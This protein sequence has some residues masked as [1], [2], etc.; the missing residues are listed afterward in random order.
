MLS[1]REPADS[2][3]PEWLS[4]L[5][6]ELVDAGNDAARVDELLAATFERFRSARVREFVPLLVERCVRRE[7]RVNP[8]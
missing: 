3:P 6:H 7:L 4:A 1:E 8:E 2:R 5:R